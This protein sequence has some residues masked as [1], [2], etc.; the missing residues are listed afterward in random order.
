[1]RPKIL[2]SKHVVWIKQK[3]MFNSRMIQQYTECNVLLHYKFVV[4]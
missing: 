1:M 4:E 2:H 3:R